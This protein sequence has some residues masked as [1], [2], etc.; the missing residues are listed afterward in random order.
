METLSQGLQRAH[1][2]EVRAVGVYGSNL[3]CE[4]FMDGCVDPI[5]DLALW[6]YATSQ[7]F[8][9]VQITEGFLA[10]LMSVCKGIHPKLSVH[11]C[12]S[13]YVERCNAP[14]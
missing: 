8:A 14:F 13:L 7:D 10:L 4:G 5:L 12:S 3:L 9:D 6:T 11:A 1:S 2:V